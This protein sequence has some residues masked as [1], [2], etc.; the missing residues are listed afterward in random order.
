LKEPGD[1]TVLVARGDLA[2]PQLAFF[3]SWGL[4]PCRLTREI[5]PFDHLI[6]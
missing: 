1:I 4:P 2:I 5:A 6:G 3:P